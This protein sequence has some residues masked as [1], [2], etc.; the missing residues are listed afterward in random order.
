MRKTHLLIEG[1]LAGLVVCEALIIWRM[2]RTCGDLLIDRKG[3][4]DLYRFEIDEL[5]SL[6]K[7][8]YVRLKIDNNANLSQH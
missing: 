1:A 5:D 8:K 4:K 6:S 2:R 7:K 3:E